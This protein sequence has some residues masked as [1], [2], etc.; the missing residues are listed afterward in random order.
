MEQEDR[1]LT[2]NICYAFT[3]SGGEYYHHVLT[4]LV[5]VFENTQSHVCAYILHDDT[6]SAQ[7]REDFALIAQRYGQEVQLRR[8]P[9]FSIDISENVWKIFGKGAAYRLF[10]PELLTVENVLYLD[11]DI[12]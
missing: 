4:S 1:I 8:V 2:L 3:D 5:S 7:A 6:V 9:P 10:I 11:S 12:I